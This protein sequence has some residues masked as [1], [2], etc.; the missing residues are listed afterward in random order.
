MA[1]EV[2]VS[3]QSA[4]LVRALKILQ[5]RGVPTHRGGGHNYVSPLSD[6]KEMS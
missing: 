4:P 3:A 1:M 2:V 5:R 6:Q